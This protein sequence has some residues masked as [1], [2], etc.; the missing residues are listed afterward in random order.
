MD[1]LDYLKAVANL[2]PTNLEFPDFAGPDPEQSQT[3]TG[4]A[5]QATATD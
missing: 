2:T 5:S 1:K 4:R 3:R